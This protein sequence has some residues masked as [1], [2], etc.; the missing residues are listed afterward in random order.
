MRRQRP[1]KHRSGQRVPERT[2]H[3]LFSQTHAEHSRKGGLSP[4][5][6]PRYFP[7]KVNTPPFRPTRPNASS[8]GPQYP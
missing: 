5:Y 3:F 1:R 8:R 6:G 4:R 7:Q 2:G